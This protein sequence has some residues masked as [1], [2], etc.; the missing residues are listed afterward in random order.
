[1]LRVRNAD[2]DGLV[3]EVIARHLKQLAAV[4]KRSGAIR[5][6][7]RWKDWTIPVIAPARVDAIRGA[8]RELDAR[9]R[10]AQNLLDSVNELTDTMI[11]GVT[12]GV[13]SVTAHNPHVPEEE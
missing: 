13:L 12:R 1:M 3:P 2:A 4:E 6:G 10:E 11:D 8:L 5:S 9:R 7:R